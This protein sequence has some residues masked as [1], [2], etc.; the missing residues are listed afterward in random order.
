MKI[1]FCAL[2][3]TLVSCSRSNPKHEEISY[4]FAG[5]HYR[6]IGEAVA[7]DAASGVGIFTVSAYLSTPTAYKISGK[8]S[9]T[10]SIEVYLEGEMV[11]QKTYHIRATYFPNG[12]WAGPGDA[13]GFDSSDHF[14]DV[15]INSYEDGVV[16]GFFS[17]RISRLVNNINQPVD[18][19]NGQ[20]IN[21]RVR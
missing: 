6:H 20:I 10:N 12:V 3:I 17:G 7:I 2:V 1:L 21:V 11:E 9:L 19:T 15:T 5:Q 8:T 18:L 16:N 4:D 14:I 13:F